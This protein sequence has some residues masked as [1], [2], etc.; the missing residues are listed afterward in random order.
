MGCDVPE[1]RLWSWIDRAAPELEPHLAQCPRCRAMAEELRAGIKTV[2]DGSTP[3][4]VSLPKEIGSYIITG[5]LGEGGQALVYKAEQQTPR[6]PVALKVLKGGRLVGDQDVRHF[7]REIQTLAGLS[8][9][10][11]ATIYEGGQT[12]EGQH[13]FA[14]ELVDGVPLDAYV[15]ERN[16]PLRERLELFC[17]VCAG[18][19]Y[20]HER[21]VIHRDLKPAN[22]LVVEEGTEARSRRRPS[23]EPEGGTNGSSG[24]GTGAP[25]VAPNGQDAHPTPSGVSGAIGQPK[26]LDFGLARLMNTDV[27]LTQTATQTG[28]IMGTLRYMS[29]GQARGDPAEIDERSDVYSLGVILY[30]LL[31]DRPPYELST[32]IPE[33]VR[34]ICETPPRRPSRTLGWDGRPARHLRGDLEMI[35]LTALEK[36]PSRRYSSVQALAEDLRRYLVGEP[37]RAKPASGL[38]VIRKKLTK[39]R[40]AIATAGV[41]TALV[42][43]SILLGFWWR[44]R[45]LYGETGSLIGVGML[46]ARSGHWQRA[47]D[48][49]TEVIRSRRDRANEGPFRTRADVYMALRRYDDAREDYTAAAKL[50]PHNPWHFYARATPL[51]ITGHRREAAEDYRTFRKL[52]PGVSYADAR[53]FLVLRDEARV[54][55][56]Q[57]RT[58]EAEELVGEA[59]EVL[60]AARRTVKKG[61]WLEEILACLAGDREPDALVAAAAEGNPRQRCEACFYAGEACLLAGQID[62]AREWFQCAEATGLV[63]DPDSASLAAMAEYHLAVWRLGQLARAEPPAEGSSGE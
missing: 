15:R 5:L 58:R 29:P 59:D 27:T 30:E 17:R 24:G 8:H 37:I 51:W 18:V 10:A 52:S 26:I 33:A 14:M 12:A 55:K 43:V 41:A 13:F 60:R 47:V 49:C 50:S 42:L 39:H 21:G 54:L 20:A 1:E 25:P 9:P 11:I 46:H 16:L 19:Q 28:Q 23:R 36:E 44:Q 63:F 61:T 31:T 62:R 4:G 6:R 38:Y 32:V 22:I 40:R 3:V 7:Q 35:V 48:I 45:A 53:L 34:T 2:A 57:G 56:Q